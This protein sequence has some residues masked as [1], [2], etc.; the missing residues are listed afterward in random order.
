MRNQSYDR[1]RD[2][3]ALYRAM[4]DWSRAAGAKADAKAFEDVAN[5]LE[6][7]TLAD[8]GTADQWITARLTDPRVQARYVE[9]QVA[10]PNE[11]ARMDREASPARRPYANGTINNNRPTPR[12]GAAGPG[13]ADMPTAAGGIRIA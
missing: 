4:G 8:L 3:I 2:R 9:R 13:A 11:A 5:M 12:P 7:Y 6:W 1:R 10:H